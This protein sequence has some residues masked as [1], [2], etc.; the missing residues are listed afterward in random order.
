M[1]WVNDERLVYTL[2]DH[3]SPWFHQQPRGLFAVDARAQESPTV[4]IRRYWEGGVVAAPPDIARARPR[5]YSLDPNHWLHSTLRDG[6]ADVLVEQGHFDGAGELI[7]TS[8]LRV[9]TTNGRSTRVADAPPGHPQ[10]WHVDGK[11]QPRLVTSVDGA[12][13]RLFWRATPQTPWALLREGPRYVA[14]RGQGVP[15]R[16]IG[17]DASDRAF[18]TTSDDQGADTTM[19]GAMD[20]RDP[21]RPI[22]AVLSTRGFDFRGALDFG[23]GNR[24]VGVHYLSDARGTHWFDTDIAAIQQQV[25]KLLPATNNVLDCGACDKPKVVLVRA[26]SDRQPEAFLLYHVAEAKLEMVSPA[27]PWIKA[28]EMASSGFERFQ[29]R[30]G[31]SIPV[32]VT[33]PAGQKGPAPAVV[34]VHGGPWMRGAEW[35]WDAIPQFLASRGYVVIEPEFRGSTGFGGKLYEAGLKQ[36]GL[37]MQDDIADAARWAVAKGWADASRL[38][39]AGASYGGYAALMGLVKDGDLYRCGVE[40]VGVTDI[41]LMYSNQWSDLPNS[42]KSYGMPELIGDRVK[43]AAQLEATSPLQQHRRIHQ[44]LLMA[45]GRQDRRVPIEHGQRLFDALKTHNSQ[46][47]WV[48][49]NDEGHGWMAERNQVDFWSRVE[50]FLDRHLKPPR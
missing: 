20:L 7:S 49:Y 18:V 2:T 24:L 16:V 35:E 1:Y 43:D 42:Y 22:K 27:R 47:D 11:G 3:K 19:L 32:H 30:D 38:C 31:L 9:D 40:W 39:I 14:S 13:E 8:L 41:D 6:S 12:F 33:R 44:P 28:E 25:D 48:V 29:A 46:V 45:H 21:G 17:V 26:Y 36:W 50:T 10:A 34:L 15:L 4:L 37:K 5:D 23:A